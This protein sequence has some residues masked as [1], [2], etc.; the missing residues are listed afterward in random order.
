MPFERKKRHFGVLSFTG[1]GHLNSLISLSQSLKDRGHKITFFEKPK[2]EDQVRQAG[3][4]F[5]PI[6]KGSSSSKGRMSRNNTGPCSK[7]SDILFN[8]ERIERDLLGGVSLLTGSVPSKSIIRT[9]RLYADMRG[10]EK[11]G[12]VVPTGIQENFAAAGG[13]NLR[14][15]DLMP[16]PAQ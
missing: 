1:T 15:S 4:D 14:L 7:L 12:A 9:S 16:E 10:A 8:L 13:Q 2:I 3:L 6:G 5:I 11:F